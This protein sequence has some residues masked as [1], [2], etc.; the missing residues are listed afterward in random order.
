[1]VRD[2]QGEVEIQR[3]KTDAMLIEAPLQPEIPVEG[4]HPVGELEVL[5]ALQSGE[6]A[7][8][9]MRTAKWREKFTIPGSSH[10]PYEEVGERLEELG[11]RRTDSGW[12]CSNA[13]RVVAYCN[14]PNCGQSPIAIRHMVEAGFPAERICYYRGGMAAW[15]VNGLTVASAHGNG[16]E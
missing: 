15:I 3:R 14:G 4:V 10:I 1:M 2:D 13:R 16:P 12:D 5:E 11:C 6:A 7:V 9:D 8:V